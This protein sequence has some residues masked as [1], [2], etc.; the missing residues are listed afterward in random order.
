MKLFANVETF[1]FKTFKKMHLLESVTT[2]LLPLVL[3]LPLM[4]FRGTL[5]AV[6]CNSPQYLDF[7]KVGTITCLFHEDFYAVLWYTEAD[8]ISNIPTL[9]YRNEVKA[10]PGYESG[11]FDVHSNGS[12]II[13][14]VS[15]DHNEMFTVAYIR[16]KEERYKSIHVS[17]I[18]VGKSNK[19]VLVVSSF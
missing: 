5:A 17:V 11:E 6:R 15:L 14:N 16:F 12:L 9:R 18:V 13:S 1:C 2:A 4:Q 3:L 8:R 19:F 7:G 10:G